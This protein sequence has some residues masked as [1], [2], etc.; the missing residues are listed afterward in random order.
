M[1]Q[2]Q[3][4]ARAAV[5]AR[6]G[7]VAKKLWRSAVEGWPGGGGMTLML[8]SNLRYPYAIQG[9]SALKQ[10]VPAKIVPFNMMNRREHALET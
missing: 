3:A 2:L 5:A 4:E 9:N 1:C 6:G 8:A 7:M 10:A